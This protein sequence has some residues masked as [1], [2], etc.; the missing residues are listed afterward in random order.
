MSFPTKVIPLSQAC[1]NW[2]NQTYA[3]R[4]HRHDDL[5]APLD[6]THDEIMSSTG[7]LLDFSRSTL[8][9]QQLDN[10]YRSRTRIFK[11]NVPGCIFFTQNK[12]SQ[13]TD[14]GVFVASH[15]GYLYRPG[16]E[17]ISVR[18]NGTSSNIERPNYI[19]YRALV[20]GNSVPDGDTLCMG[21]YSIT[22]GTSTYVYP[23]ST[24]GGGGWINYRFIFVPYRCV[25]LS[26]PASKYFTWVGM[27]DDFL[28]QNAGVTGCGFLFDQAI[29]NAFSGD[30]RDNLTGDNAIYLPIIFVS[31]TRWGWNSIMNNGGNNVDH[32]GVR[33]N[34]FDACATGRDR[35]WIQADDKSNR[36][37]YWDSAGY[38][39]LGEGNNQRYRA[40][41]SNGSH[42]P[43]DLSWY[44]SYDSNT[45]Q[46]ILTKAVTIE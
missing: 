43:W 33:F 12:W 20:G 17:T 18:W 8:M 2:L 5:Y 29:K 4:V 26:V 28:M 25:D 19:E 32:I 16:K 1:K 44:N 22:P 23:S 37:I 6:H 39:A 9:S 15:P 7:G 42:D 41:D 21:W 38:W 40:T 46:C 30:W 45:N 27:A 10:S 3:P 13:D 36:Q 31:G 11:I 14:H 34:L 24:L 35:R